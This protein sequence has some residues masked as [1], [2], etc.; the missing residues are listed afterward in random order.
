M[1]PDTASFR[2]GLRSVG[3]ESHAVHT[4]ERVAVRRGSASRPEKPPLHSRLQRGQVPRRPVT[5]IREGQNDG[6]PNTEANTTWTP[7]ITTFTPPYPDYTSGANGVTA[8]YVGTLIQFLGRDKFDF[9]VTTV[10]RN[11][12][13]DYTRSSDVMRD[14]VDVRVLQGIHFRFADQAGRNQDLAVAHWVF[15]HFL[16]HG[17]DK[18]KDK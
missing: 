2:P 14:I 1:A 9:T 15:R 16:H 8:A 3:L 6:N 10:P 11:L 17:R 12:S 4:Q 18:D 5:A 7:F 13:R